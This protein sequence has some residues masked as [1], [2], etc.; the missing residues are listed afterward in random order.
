M[1]RPRPRPVA[2]R[3]AT[4]ADVPAI[5]AIAVDAWRDTYRGL[6]RDETIEWFVARAYTE[7]RVTLRVE[8]HETWVATLDGS[9]GAF[10]ETAL[11]PDRVD[12][13][14]IYAD[15]GRRRRGLGS[16]LLDAIVRTHPDLPI[17][18]DVLA[19]NRLG[20]AWYEARGFAPR[21]DIEEELGGELVVER[22]WWRT[23][24]G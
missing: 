9:V 20:E 3:R 7:E 17:V 22:R 1:P 23:A 24:G 18:A 11:E 8:R 13:V 10:A 16:A 12:L 6:L 4:A 14:A 5:R 19:G 2:V 15:P 21:E